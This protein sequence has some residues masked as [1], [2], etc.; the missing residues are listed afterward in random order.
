MAKCLLRYAFGSIDA[1]RDLIHRTPDTDTT[2]HPNKQFEVA[3][4]AGMRST[5]LSPTEDGC[6]ADIN[7]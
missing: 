4:S 3:R 5:V 2:K 6:F 1:G 7:D